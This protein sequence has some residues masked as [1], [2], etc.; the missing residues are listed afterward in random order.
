MTINFS[1]FVWHSI[2]VL[3]LLVFFGS[4]ISGFEFIVDKMPVCRSGD[5]TGCNEVGYK[6]LSFF[7]TLSRY[8]LVLVPFFAIALIGALMSGLA[9]IA[10]SI[11]E[12]GQAAKI[13]RTL[14]EQGD[15]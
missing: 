3:G 5:L 10:H 6:V 11:I 1:K 13:Y 4:L 7:D 15:I 8:F 2:A 14:T 9:G 12:L